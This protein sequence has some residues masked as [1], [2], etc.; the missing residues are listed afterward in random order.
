MSPCE[1][2]VKKHSLLV[3]PIE[4]A[5]VSGA[6]GRGIVET[7]KTDPAKRGPPSQAIHFRVQIF[8]F[9]TTN[10]V[11][12]FTQKTLNA[13]EMINRPAACEIPTDIPNHRSFIGVYPPWPE[14]RVEKWRVRRFAIPERL[15]D[16]YFGEEDLIDSELIYLD[17]LENVEQLLN[18]WGVDTAAFDAPWNSDYPL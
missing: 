15:I 3:D 14:K 2:E 12:A 1:R 11:M 9:V 6:G 13:F 18:Q 17:G 5:L 10:N 4:A 7:V 16:E 8:E